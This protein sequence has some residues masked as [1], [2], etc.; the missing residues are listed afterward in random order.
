MIKTGFSFIAFIIFFT[1]MV[2][3]ITKKFPCKLYKILPPVIIIY[4]SIMVMYTFG[5][6]EMTESV[7]TTRSAFINNLVPAMIFLM[8]LKCN[9]REIVK[10]GPRLTITFFGATFGVMLG[11]IGAFI[12][13]KGF[14]PEG[15]HLAFSAMSAGWMGGTQNFLA[16]KSAIGVTDELMTN[17][18]LMGNICYSILIMILVGIGGYKAV[19]NKWTKTDYAP[20]ERICETLKLDENKDTKRIDFLDLFLVIGIGLFVSMVSTSLSTMLPKIGFIDAGIWKILIAT[21]AGIGCALTPLGKL[22]GLDEISNIILYLILVLTASNVNLKALITAPIY[23]VAGLVILVIIFLVTALIAKLFKF[24]LHTCGIAIIANVG[25]VAS[26][27]IIA[28]TYDKSLVSIS[29]LMSLL[30]DIAGT[31]L[32]FGVLE[33]LKFFI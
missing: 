7:A 12:I 24:D 8:C 5:V 20:I 11:F 13:F 16:V 14:F 1:A 21:F 3:V 2:L 29:V 31:F 26:A 23:I 32:A 19:F 9:L 22:R 28:A 33:I 17:T 4:L 25:G 10:L 15:T 27:P 6:W 30:G 18:L